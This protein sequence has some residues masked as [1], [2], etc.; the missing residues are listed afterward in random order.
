MMAQ[1][2]IRL[3]YKNVTSGVIGRRHG[4]TPKQLESLA[5]KTQPFISLI[6]KQRRAGLTPYRDLPYNK[7]IPRRVNSIVKNLRKKC[8]YLVVLGIG[9]S[10]LGPQFVEAPRA[11][12]RRLEWELDQIHPNVTAIVQ[13]VE[14]LTG[15]LR[16][17]LAAGAQVVIRPLNHTDCATVSRLLG[18]Y[19]RELLYSQQADEARWV[20]QVRKDCPD[21]FVKIV[22][23]E[24]KPE[25]PVTTE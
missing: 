1:T 23:R 18:E 25:P 19:E 21:C 4:I 17:R 7:D 16:R 6:N 8:D 15:R 9:G 20:E 5:K 13:R 12:S 22:A 3:Y 14:R 11:Y 2:Q 10:A 24:E